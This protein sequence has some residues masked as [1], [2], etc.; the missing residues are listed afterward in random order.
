MAGQS[1]VFYKVDNPVVTTGCFMQIS[2]GFDCPHLISFTYCEVWHRQ[3][4][5]G[6]HPPRQIYTPT[7]PPPRKK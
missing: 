2:G 1:S 5:L 7:P 3:I 6:V 4:F